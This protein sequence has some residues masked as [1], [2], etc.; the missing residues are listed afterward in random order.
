MFFRNQLFVAFLR[1]WACRI[2]RMP[3]EPFQVSRQIT[4]PNFLWKK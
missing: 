2:I 4:L 3:G 1:P